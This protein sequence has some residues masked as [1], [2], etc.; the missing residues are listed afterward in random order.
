MKQKNRTTQIRN[1]GRYLTGKTRYT[2]KELFTIAMM[3]DQIRHEATG[4]NLLDAQAAGH[5][6]Y[7]IAQKAINGLVY[8]GETVQSVASLAAR[9]QSGCWGDQDHDASVCET[10]SQ[11]FW[12]EY[13]KM[14]DLEE[15]LALREDTYFEDFKTEVSLVRNLQDWSP[16]MGPVSAS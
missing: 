6:D 16:G 2:N 4:L 5:Y 9:A 15:H 3:L 14:A 1:I 11:Y 12:K 13:K 7:M 10:C 8:R